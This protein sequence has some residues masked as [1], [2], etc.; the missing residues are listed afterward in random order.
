MSAHS[1]AG[2]TSTTVVLDLGCQLHL[3]QGATWREDLL[4]PV[5]LPL[6][7]L[8]SDQF[9]SRASGTYADSCDTRAAATQRREPAQRQALGI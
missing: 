8:Q 7:S 5:A 4:A 3:R 9:L 1:N 2:A 6:D